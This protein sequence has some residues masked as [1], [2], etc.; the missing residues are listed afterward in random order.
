MHKSIY[1]TNDF[2][3]IFSTDTHANGG[4][5]HTRNSLFTDS[6]THTRT[7]A[8]FGFGE[9]L[10]KSS[11]RAIGMGSERDMRVI[12]TSDLAPHFSLRKNERRCDE[13]HWR[14]RR[15]RRLHGCPLVKL[16]MQRHITDD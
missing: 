5:V 16:F 10:N 7:P 8:K 13:W 1:Q 14:R 4:H 2:V 9:N 12:L 11:S 6:H 15:R 3:D